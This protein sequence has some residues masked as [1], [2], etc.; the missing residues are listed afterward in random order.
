VRLLFEER[1]RLFSSRRNGT[2]PEDRFVWGIGEIFCPLFRKLRAKFF[3]IFGGG[4]KFEASI[5]TTIYGRLDSQRCW[6]G[7]GK[8]VRH[9]AFA[10]FDPGSNIFCA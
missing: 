5:N 10:F 3:Q 1:L 8:L 4:A 7:M 2:D 9:Q 6:C